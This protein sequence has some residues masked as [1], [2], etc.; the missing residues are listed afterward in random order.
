MAARIL[1]TTEEL[2]TEA[3][4]LEK[5]ARENDEVLKTLDKIVNGVVS[6][7]EGEAQKAFADSYN[8]KKATFTKLTDQMLELAKDVK[9]FASNMETTERQEK[10]IAG[11]LGN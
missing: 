2:K 3:A 6:G 10:D 8:K 9:V 5:A 1:L 11:K 7:W 4:S